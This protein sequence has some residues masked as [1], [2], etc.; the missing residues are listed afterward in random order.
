MKL[1]LVVLV[2]LVNIGACNETSA[3][4]AYIML[5][6]NFFQ[7]LNVMT[8]KLLELCDIQVSVKKYLSH[9]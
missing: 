5:N 6:I 2:K 9:K 4:V 7:V 8:N 3:A 1:A